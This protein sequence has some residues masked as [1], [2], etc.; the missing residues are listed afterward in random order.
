[1][2]TNECN[3]EVDNN[4]KVK[5]KKIMWIFERKFETVEEKEQYLEENSVWAVSGSSN[6]STGKRTYY[7]CNLVKKKGPQCAARKCIFENNET[8]DFVLY[9]T[10]DEHTHSDILTAVTKSIR[11]IVIDL[12]KH[13]K[14]NQNRYMI[15]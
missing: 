3:K 2:G 10:N 9:T 12:Y 13:G 5:K 1:M 15:I 14:P 7:R 4:S 11:N 8:T 6:V